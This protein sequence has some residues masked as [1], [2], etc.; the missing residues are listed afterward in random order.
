MFTTPRLP[1]GGPVARFGLSRAFEAFGFCDGS[2]KRLTGACGSVLLDMSGAQLHESW[3]TLDRSV[4]DSNEAEFEA[5]LD[6]VSVAANLGIPSLWVG[7]DS[8]QVIEHALKG[9]TR[10]RLATERLRELGSRFEYLEV[11]AIDRSRNKKANALARCGI[12]NIR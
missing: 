1:P 12:R 9:S 4:F 5:L 10:Y 2:V 6:T 11:Q 7:T 3:R 8:F